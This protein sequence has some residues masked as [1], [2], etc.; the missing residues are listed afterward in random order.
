MYLID[1]KRDIEIGLV[2]NWKRILE[3][4]ASSEFG[5][6][7]VRSAKVVFTLLAHTDPETGIVE[8][9]KSKMAKDL[10][11]AQPN[12]RRICRS[13]VRVGYLHEAVGRG[14]FY[15]WNNEISIEHLRDVFLG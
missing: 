8:R 5:V 9:E 2:M 7:G 14:S 4:L 11:M 3:L 6:T 10:E 12:F 1:T 13:L 15:R